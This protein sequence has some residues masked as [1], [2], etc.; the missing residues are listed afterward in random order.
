M[1][2]STEFSQA[3]IPLCRMLLELLAIAPHPEVC[4][5]NRVIV[6][7]TYQVPDSELQFEVHSLKNKTES[8]SRALTVPPSGAQFVARGLPPPRVLLGEAELEA[9]HKS[10]EFGSLEVTNTSELGGWLLLDGNPLAFITPRTRRTFGRVPRGDYH[11]ELRSFF[12]V[13]LL[14]PGPVK[15]EKLTRVGEPPKVDAG[16]PAADHSPNSER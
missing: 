9:L 3:G 6:R 8:P 11:L 1:V 16:A 15:V 12:G 10:D 5:D 7:A 4:A 14:P 13:Q 2:E